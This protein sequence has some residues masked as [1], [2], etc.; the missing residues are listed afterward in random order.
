MTPNPAKMATY[1][2]P[3]PSHIRDREPW[4]KQHFPDL[5]VVHASFE[6]TSLWIAEQV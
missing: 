2:L 1:N 4:E 5:Q 3:N 6:D